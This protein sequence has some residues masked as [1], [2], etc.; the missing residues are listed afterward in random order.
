MR[1]LWKE[2]NLPLGNDKQLAR[3]NHVISRL[4][5]YSPASSVCIAMIATNAN[6]LSWPCHFA[7]K[8]SI[9]PIV[10]RHADSTI[11]VFDVFES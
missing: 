4:S 6:M 8:V 5:I 2:R 11:N 10:H 1:L 9:K 7:K 3:C